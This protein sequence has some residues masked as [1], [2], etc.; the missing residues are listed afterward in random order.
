MVTMMQNSSSNKHNDEQQ[1][2]PVGVGEDGPLSTSSTNRRR[3]RLRHFVILVIIICVVVSNMEHFSGSTIQKSLSSSE[4]KTLSMMATTAAI[5]KKNTTVTSTKTTTAKAHD[6]HDGSHDDDEGS[7]SGTSNQ[8][9]V[10]MTSQPPQP[11]PPPPLPSVLVAA[12]TAET[13]ESVATATTSVSQILHDTN[14]NVTLQSQTPP[15][16]TPKQPGATAEGGA[17]ASGA[18]TSVRGIHDEQDSPQPLDQD[19]NKKEDDNDLSR[20]KVDDNNNNNKNSKNPFQRI[21]LM[22][23]FNYVKSDFNINVL[24][25]WIEK[26]TP[27]FGKVIIRGEFWNITQIEEIR[28]AIPNI[29][30]QRPDSTY[31][32][33][34]KYGKYTGFYT[35]MSNLK[36]ALLEYQNFS[37]LYDGVLYM[38]DDSIPNLQVLAGIQHGE[39]DDDDDKE[40]YYNSYYY[41][42]DIGGNLQSEH[43]RKY[44]IVGTTLGTMNYIQKNDYSYINPRDVLRK[45]MLMNTLNEEVV[46]DHDHDNLEGKYKFLLRKS[47]RIYAKSPNSNN[48]T[49]NVFHPFGTIDGTYK[50]KTMHELNNN[51]LDNWNMRPQKRC[52]GGQYDMV[53]SFSSRNRTLLQ[54]KYFEY[55]DYKYNHNY[56]NNTNNTNNNTNNN[57]YMIFPAYTQSDLL[58]M[59]FTYTSTFV[60]LATL[61]EKYNVW[62]ECAIPTIVDQIQRIHG[63]GAGTGTSSSTNQ[64]RNHSVPVPV[65]VNVIPLCTSWKSSRGKP[66]MALVC[67]NATNPTYHGVYHPIKPGV[68]INGWEKVFDRI[69]DKYLQSIGIS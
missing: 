34:N 55:D 5:G 20:D 54:Q 8:N 29:D 11:P 21:I 1:E 63:V 53:H 48:N 19:S 4:E 69:N 33:P 35:P 50:T 41:R 24:K 52:M 49:N 39:S 18:S 28:A 23:Q 25:R 65:V 22:G 9:K 51:K 47:Y 6:G 58:Y 68:D 44:G 10:N 62:I 61:L 13:G 30:I 2:Q 27:I 37:N 59:P 56:N 57:P 7:K 12:E 45:K 64:G 17:G 16:T 36:H 26:F 14:N 15:P 38:H 60:Q 31:T 40:Y 42:R 32:K 67:V 46:D 43:A 3:R 66:Y